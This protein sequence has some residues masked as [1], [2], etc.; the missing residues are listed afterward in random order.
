MKKQFMLA[1]WTVRAF[2]LNTYIELKNRRLETSR[3]KWQ[4]LKVG[5]GG[6][7]PLGR[8]DQET[9]IAKTAKFG[10]VSFVDT[11]VAVVFY[12]DIFRSQ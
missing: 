10:S 9:A 4:A 1:Y 5:G 12:S 8:V 11:E 6:V 3:R 7:V 2:A